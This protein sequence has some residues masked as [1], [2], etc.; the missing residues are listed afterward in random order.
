MWDASSG[1][2]QR[3]LKTD[4]FRVEELVTTSYWLRLGLLERFRIL[5]FQLCQ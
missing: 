5:G 4:D 1:S 3:E 2:G